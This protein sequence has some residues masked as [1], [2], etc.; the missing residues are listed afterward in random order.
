[1]EGLWRAVKWRACGVEGGVK[2]GVRR[3]A[4][5]H[6]LRQVAAH[7]A[8]HLL[9]E[10]VAPACRL[11]LL[12]HGV[13]PPTH[14]ARCLSQPEA[15]AEAAEPPSLLAERRQAIPRAQQ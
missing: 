1:M 10:L 2:G 11:A 14:R 3:R 12:G 15:H 13:D 8:E 4:C 9:P 6:R 5:T 7:P